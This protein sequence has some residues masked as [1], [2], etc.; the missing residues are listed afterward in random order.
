MKALLYTITLSIAVI[1]LS[2]CDTENTDSENLKPTDHNPSAITV[3]EAQFLSSDMKLGRIIENTFHEKVKLTGVFDVP[4]DQKAK[5]STY[6]A[7]KI[8]YLDILKGERVR[9]GQ[10]LLILESPEYLQLQQEYLETA[11]EMESLQS[12]YERKKKLIEGNIASQ[13]DF[14]KAEADYKVIRVRNQTLK[15]KLALIGINA[16]KLAVDN[17]KST[18]NIQSPID[19]FITDINVTK[20]SSLNPNETAIEIVDTDHMHLELKLFEQDFQKVKVGQ[21]ISFSVQN[22]GDIKHTATVHL[23]NRNVDPDT[24]T[25]G[26]HAHLA[27]EKSSSLFFPGMYVEAEIHTTSRSNPALP[28]SAVIELGGTY[29]VLELISVKKGIYTL[30]KNEVKIGMIENGLVEILNSEDFD[31]DSQFLIDGAYNLIKE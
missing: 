13:K 11:G 23:I 29:Y 5:I 18:I 16:D 2:A 17:L 19:G 7:G 25:I 3:T 26:L 10:T 22:I 9:K 4:P 8:I 24:R 12:D 15:Q 30:T 31:S 27:D 21:P 28:Q 1:L 20:G 14:A 6:Y